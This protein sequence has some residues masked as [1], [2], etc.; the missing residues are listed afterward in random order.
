MARHP[1]HGSI[2]PQS[3]HSFLDM[4]KKGS[5]VGEF[6][7]HFGIICAVFVNGQEAHDFVAEFFTMNHSF[8][9]LSECDLPSR[10]A[11]V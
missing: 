5:S 11:W 10:P 4:L 6:N 8:P 7:M 3:K 2:S 1:G 9:F